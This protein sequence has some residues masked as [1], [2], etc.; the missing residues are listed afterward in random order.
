LLGLVLRRVNGEEYVT[1]GL[2][3]RLE[4]LGRA[5]LLLRRRQEALQK[6]REEVLKLFLDNRPPAKDDKLMQ[7]R[8][9]IREAYLKKE[10]AFRQDE[11]ELNAILHAYLNYRDDLD[12]LK[13]VRVVVCGLAWNDGHPVDGS[14]ALARYID[15]TPLQ[16]V[17]WFQPS[18][19]T[20]GQAWAGLIRDAD[21]NGVMEFAEKKA[22]LPAGSWNHEFNFLAWQPAGKGTGG[23]E[24]PARTQ[25]LPDRTK[26]RVTMQWR[27]AHDASFAGPGEDPYRNPLADLRLMVLRQPDPEGKKRPSDDFI[28]VTESIGLAQRIANTPEASTFE[29]VVEF[30]VDEASRYALRIEGTLP[31]GTEPRGAATLPATQQRAE[32]RPRLYVE[33]LGG[34]GRVVLESYV[35]DPGTLGTPGDALRVLTVGAVSS[36]GQVRSYSTEGAPLNVELARKPDV[37]ADDRLGLEG[38]KN[39]GGTGMSAAFAAGHAA[40]LLSGGKSPARVRQELRPCT[41]VLLPVPRKE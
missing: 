2:S 19:N 12:R 30:T 31:V 1:E 32:I 40:V 37:Q 11:K 33:T 20:R 17:L 34:D 9:E 27:E 16:S 23:R 21:G 25:A 28:F 35:T 24:F 7:R 13:D 39:V 29:H 18:G 3:R 6:E 5:R 22:P 14:G 26:V 15:D 10:A 38:A 4:D 8:L 41:P 36:S